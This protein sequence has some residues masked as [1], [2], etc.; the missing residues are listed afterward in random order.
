MAVISGVNAPHD[1]YLNAPN[2]G[3]LY[4]AYGK[5]VCR[6]N[7]DGVTCLFI[8]HKPI[9]MGINEANNALFNKSDKSTRK[10]VNSRNST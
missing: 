8:T 3:L 5:L 6:L 9:N 4:H 1:K 2:Q 7:V 10:A